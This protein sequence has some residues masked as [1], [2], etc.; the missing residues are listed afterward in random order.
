VKNNF[1]KKTLIVIVFSIV[2]LKPFAQMETEFISAGKIKFERKT[3]MH[4]LYFTDEEMSSWDEMFKKMF[5]QFRVNL[6]ELSFNNNQSL[7]KTAKDNPEVKMGFFGETPGSSNTVF[8]DLE[9]ETISSQKQ[10][11]ESMFLISDSIPQYEWKL[12]S[13]TRTIANFE[14][15]KAITK[16]CDSVVVVAFYTE[17]IPCSSGPESFGG[18]PGMILGLAI[19]RLYTTWFA[20]SLELTNEPPIAP[21]KGK[22]TD[23]KSLL[24]T[25]NDG[26][27]KWDEKW[28]NRM[29]W[30]AVL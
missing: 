10:I 23:S 12:Q 15:K 19:P 30:Q 1:M 20:T 4:R 6:F 9:K 22:K 7:Y 16:I 3:N 5:P 27:G 8:K 24:K 11:F 21:A 26:I 28:R 18:L 14:C 13:E 2:C 25:I 17:E 29:I